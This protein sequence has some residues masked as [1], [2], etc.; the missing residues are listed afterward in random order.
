MFV[1]FVGL[2]FVGA[3]CTSGAARFQSRSGEIGVVARVPGEDACGCFADVCAVQVRAN[4]L[5]QLGDHVLTQTSVGAR[6][7]GLRAF[8]ACFNTFYER[9]LVNL[10]EIFRVSA[11]HF[12][13]NSHDGFLSFEGSRIRSRIRQR[14]PIERFERAC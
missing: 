12:S 14:H 11:E 5:C 10:T 1:H 6:C 8:N 7:T 13:H 9:L 4:A 2:T 3:T